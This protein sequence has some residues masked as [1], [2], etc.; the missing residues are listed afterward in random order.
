LVSGVSKEANAKTTA[1]DENIAPAYD[2]IPLD[3]PTTASEKNNAPVYDEI[4]LDSPTTGMGARILAQG[5]ERSNT[6]Q[7]EYAN[8]GVKTEGQKNEYENLQ[9]NEYEH[10]Q[11]HA[12]YT[13]V[14][15]T[16]DLTEA[17]EYYNTRQ[18]P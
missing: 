12:T 4:P 3:P 11:P 7:G 8:V 16:P 6:G 14:Y 13:T 17:G 15:A 5:K 10:L 9:K 18:L 2:E 1:S